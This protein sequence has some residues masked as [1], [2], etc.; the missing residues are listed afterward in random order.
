MGWKLA[1]TANVFFWISFCLH[2]V[3]TSNVQTTQK[4]NVL[5][6]IADDLR[7]TLGCYGDE[8][9]L[10]PSIDS[11]ARDGLLFTNAH[12]QQALCGPSRTSFLTSRRPDTIRIYENHCHYWRHT[13]G[14]FTTIPQY[15][16]EHGY[17]TASVG[18]VFHPGPP[19]GR[20]L[21][22][23][24]SWSVKPFTPKSLYF[25]N[26]EVCPDPSGGPKANLLC[27]VNVSTQPLQTLPDLEN[28]EVA[29]KFLS[30]WT[31]R[32]GGNSPQMP[33]FLAVGFYKP[34]IP[35]RIPKEYLDLYPIAHIKLP[36]DHELP[37][38]LP[39]VAWNPWTDV[40]RRHDASL[41]NVSFPYGP[42]PVD[43]QKK[44]RQ[45]YYAAVTYMDKQVG[46]VL[47][48][49]DKAGL[50]ND[51]L[52]VFVGDHGWALG[53]H[54][55][56]SKFSNFQVATNVP[57]VISP[58]RSQRSLSPAKVAERVD[59]PVA[60][61]DLFPTLASLASL[62]A[63]PRCRS[64]GYSSLSET[65]CTDGVNLANPVQRKEVLHQ[66]PRPSATPQLNSDQPVLGDIRIMGYS[67]VSRDYRYTEW[68]GFDATNFRRNWTNVYA[69]ELYNLNSD[70]REDS[71]VANSPKYKDLVIALSSRLR[72]LVEN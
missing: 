60:L 61:V 62:P 24:Y 19:T 56:Y 52:I 55:E 33:F 59:D 14:N 72:E 9:A 70:P 65:T 50:R 35:F 20:H 22:Y 29:T 46:K 25:E 47:S 17:H 10:T 12:A 64:S 43:F 4:P 54:Q 23:P 18:K 30:K 48:A 51:T 63:P 32:E 53:E 11:L 7:P 28:V 37:A 16:K 2:Q 49:L 31:S 58:P 39:P 66:Y 45:H 36:P 57:L 26:K 38:D 8:L 68:I 3:M 27:A 1:I 21:D 15:F 42:L 6:I 41:L 40:R 67:M 34:H 5:L 44:I 13:V 71:N 69:R